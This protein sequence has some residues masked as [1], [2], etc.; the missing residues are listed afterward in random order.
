[1]SIKGSA[2]RSGSRLLGTRSSLFLQESLQAKALLK[3]WRLPARDPIGDLL[4]MY[5]KHSRNISAPRGRGLRE[6]SSEG[7][8]R[9]GPLTG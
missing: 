9:L 7:K 8:A 2:G 3:S 6:I 1:M 4:A 5:A